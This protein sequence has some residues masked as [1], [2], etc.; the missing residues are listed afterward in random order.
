MKVGG[1]QANHLALPV[2][3]EAAYCVLENGA[4]FSRFL[5]S[6]F[7]LA[8]DQK[9]NVWQSLSAVFNKSR[10]YDVASFKYAFLFLDV[11]PCVHD[12]DDML[13]HFI[14][15]SCAMRVC[16]RHCGEIVVWAE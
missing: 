14:D 4:H 3:G 7:S 11:N 10:S 2:A 12:I 15:L 9:M 13:K 6:D 8:A 1:L 16:K 5:L